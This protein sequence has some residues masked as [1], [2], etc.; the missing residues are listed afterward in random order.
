LVSCRSEP[1]VPPA[2][3]ILTNGHIFTS[4]PAVPWAEAVAVRDGK[5]LAVG[6]SK[7]VAKYQGAATHVIDLHG[8]MAMPGII[9]NHTHFLWASYGLAGVQ[10]REARTP[11]EMKKV[12]QEYAKAHPDEQ[13][14]WGS[15]GFMT[16]PGRQ[17]KAL[18]D[19]A[20]P[21]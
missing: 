15:Y 7:D 1:P 18:L 20:F 8:R 9:D 3:I 10:L 17:A 4:N 14:V 5:V 6:S 12:T 16:P 2:E 21:D 13:W 19:E 11:A